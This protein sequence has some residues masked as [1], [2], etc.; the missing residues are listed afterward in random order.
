[1][2]EAPEDRMLACRY[3]L[4][5]LVPMSLAAAVEAY[6]RPHI[7]LDRYSQVRPGGYY[8]I[9]SQ[10]L[11]SPDLKLFRESAEGKANR[12][13]LRI[14]SYSDEP[15][16]PCF[17]EIKRRINTVIVKS[18]ARLGRGDVPRVLA[19]LPGPAGMPVRDREVLRQFQLYRT[20]LQAGPMARVRY[21]RKAY[22][23]DSHSRVRI[24]LDRQ[25]CCHVDDTA[26]V[27]LDGAG[28]Q[29]LSIRDVVLE[30]KYTGRYPAWLVR[31]IQVLDLRQQSVS[32]YCCSI[33]QA[34]LLGIRAPRIAEVPW[35]S[36]SAS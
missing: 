4:K 9:V 17:L 30:I 7:R 34:S 28:W 5:Y 2:A 18:R 31:M 27:R 29:A 8:P 33:R 12:I 24:T 11:D 10:Y 16:S 23:D 19:G 25:L 26:T 1:M 6:I 36:C 15:V 35:T 3:E 13:K 14:R 22:E 20:L 21:L 32:K